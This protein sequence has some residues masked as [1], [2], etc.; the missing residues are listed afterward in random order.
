[1]PAGD[2]GSPEGGDSGSDDAGAKSPVDPTYGTAGVA[3]ATFDEA[4]ADQI[5]AAVAR[6]DGSVILAGTN[7][8]WPVG[9]VPD[10]EPMLLSIDA[11]GVLDASFGSKG[12]A[13]LPIGSGEFRGVALQAD[14]KVVAVGRS[15]YDHQHWIVARFTAAGALDPTFG[16]GSGWLLESSFY[17][18][19]NAVVVQADGRIVG[20][21]LG[22]GGPALIRYLANGTR[23]ASFGSAGIWK[24][25]MWGSPCFAVALAGGGLVCA[26][27]GVERVTSTGVTET[28]FGMAGIAAMPTY[29]GA[30]GL[31][32]DGSGRIVASGGYASAS[33]EVARFT[34]AGTVDATF[35]TNGAS[36]ASD[37]FS[38]FP[39]V[40]TNPFV[41]P[42]ALA[43]GTIAWGIDQ[44]DGPHVLRFTADGQ[45]DPAFGISGSA[46]TG[47]GAASSLAAVVPL[48]AGKLLA[49]GMRFDSTAHTLTP[50]LVRHIATG[51]VAASYA[52]AGSALRP[53]GLTRSSARTVH[54]QS[55]GKALVVGTQARA[56][57]GRATVA[58]FDASGSL[59]AAFGTGGTLLDAR[60]TTVTDATVDGLGRVVVLGTRVDVNVGQRTI[61]LR[62][63]ADGTPDATFGDGGAVDLTAYTPGTGDALAVDA[64]NRVVVGGDQIVQGSTQTLLVRV[65]EA[66]SVD[67]TFGTSG[68]AAPRGGQ[69]VALGVTPDGKILAASS[70]GLARYD[71][72]GSLD[73]TFGSAGVA[74][75]D[76]V[77]PMDVGSDGSIVTAAWFGSG[78]GIRVR[79]LLSNGTVDVGFGAAGAFDEPAATRH[80]EASVEMLPPTLART[81]SGAVLVAV[82][83]T[84]ACANECMHVFRLTS[85]GALDP[86]FATGGRATLAFGA[87]N[88]FVAGVALQPDGKPLLA[89]STWSPSTGPTLSL[90]RLVP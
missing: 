18:G 74:S 39:P 54:V 67:A 63:L 60:I 90:V 25:P 61:A 57:V 70:T 43:D 10:G 37:L 41:A 85:K 62:F 78:S 42:S 58:R 88:A 29:G 36:T 32:V 24:G 87:G 82:T 49:V 47:S 80:T 17:G 84:L 4:P 52:T 33:A 48:D 79:R 21:G 73:A 77:G 81:P 83:S 55:D 27:N 12:R 72:A 7:G 89:G 1:M 40:T 3:A 13:L 34:T 9:W 50:E 23:D 38:L 6:P 71:A 69:I 26:S 35:G 64:S 19:A 8:V 56:P 16:G 45:P 2:A 68:Y 30:W 59:D 86:T 11:S 44:A 28:A 46:P 22:M 75:V 15:L 65:T 20:G 14:G 76:V 53:S 51:A 5:Y 31:A 66:G